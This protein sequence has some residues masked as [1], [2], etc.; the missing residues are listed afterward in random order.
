[1]HGFYA[2]MG[3]FA[4][5][6]D[7][8]TASMTA[9]RLK[10]DCKR[11]TIT[12]RGVAL[13]ADCQLLPEVDKAYISDKSKSDGLSKFLA[14][15]QAAWLIVQLIGRLALGLEVTLL[16]VNTL[17][18]VFCALIIY[19]IWWHKPRMVLEP[20][21]LKGDWV[22][23]LA[24][25]MYMSSRMSGGSVDTL[26]VPIDHP[27]KS[28]I[29]SLAFFPDRPCRQR[30]DRLKTCPNLNNRHGSISVS[31]NKHVPAAEESLLQ[32]NSSGSFGLR[33]KSFNCTKDGCREESATE[34]QDP[35]SGQ[36][37]RWS[38]AAEAI[39]EY[40]AIRRRFTSVLQNNDPNE[41]T[42]YLVELHPE[43]LV[44]EHCSNWSTAGLE[45]GDYGLVMG[46]SMWFASMA[47]A[48]IHAAAWHSFFPSQT[49]AWLWRCSAIYIMWSGL[50]W[51]LINLV[52][53]VAKP[54]D[55]YWNSIRLPYAPFASSTS[56]VVVCFLCGSLYTF[57]RIFLVL[58][59]FISI[60][61]LPLDAYE[62]PDWAQI[63]PHF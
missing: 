12:A 46:I 41:S 25:Y 36:L 30:S 1:M 60:R 24:A 37:L 43:E 2:G 18:H 8:L 5:P 39:R 34:S 48:G 58:E 22:G 54:F 16:E 31:K 20:I 27:A 61:Q 9:P 44:Q 21:V 19:I 33:P 49:E 29:K 7:N 56:L 51:C 42:M 47:F 4:F 11:L 10:S 53:K 59:A 45:P 57:A 40:P 52:A 17:G 63:I 26:G 62:T 35:E 3:G 32:G 50:V 13:L 14:C 38:L 6:L 28:E 23:P 55:D 15:I